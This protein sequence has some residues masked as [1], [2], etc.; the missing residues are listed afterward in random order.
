MLD[1][2]QLCQRLAKY[3]WSPR[4]PSTYVTEH[5]RGLGV[6]A[7]RCY[8]SFNLIWASHKLDTTQDHIVAITSFTEQQLQAH[9]MVKGAELG[10]W[11]TLLTP[12]ELSFWYKD[13]AVYINRLTRTNIEKALYA[14]QHVQRI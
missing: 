12:H 7:N 11:L 10:T 6:L 4:H 5:G 2:K 8:G 9:Q 1:P 3:Y 13:N 14:L